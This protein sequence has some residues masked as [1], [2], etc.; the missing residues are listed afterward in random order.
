MLAE[1]FAVAV[2]SFR[3][4]LFEPLGERRLAAEVDLCDVGEGEEIVPG[5]AC[6]LEG[7]EALGEGGVAC[8]GDV[9][10][11][12]GGFADGME[13]V[14]IGAG[15]DLRCILAIPLVGELR[16]MAGGKC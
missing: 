1:G 11:E 16:E 8:L 12:L 4:L 5:A 9:A 7:L 6:G 15:V 2:E 13:V 10:G 3:M 14:G